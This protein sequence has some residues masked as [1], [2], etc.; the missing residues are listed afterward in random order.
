MF[1]WLTTL[2]FVLVLPVLA[3]AQ[4]DS[5]LITDAAPEVGIVRN[6]RGNHVWSPDSANFYLLTAFCFVENG[7]TLTIEP[8]TVIK[9]EPG[10]GADAS[11]LIV[12]RGGHIIADGTADRPIIFT[13]QSDDVDD[14]NDL[15]QNIRGLWGGLLVLGI[16]GT[17]VAG[18][19]N[20]IEGIPTTEPRGIYGPGSSFVKDD[21]DN[22]GIVRYVS[23]RYGGSV[24]GLNNE[25]NG[26]TLGAVGDGTT[27]EYV[28]SFNN[29]DDGFE[30]FGG[31]VNTRYLVS[32]R[33]DDD[34]F[35]YD[36]GWRG[37]NQFWL[38]LMDS[39]D[40]N[41]GGEHDGGTTPEDGTPYATPTIS[42][43]TYV[44]AGAT[45]LNAGNDWAVNLRDNAGG[46]YYNSIFTDFFGSGVQIEDLVSGQDSRQ[47]LDD[48]HLKFE[49]NIFW[50]FG[51]GNASTD[52]WPQPFVETYMT[53]GANDNDIVD[54]Q[55]TGMPSAS[56]DPLADFDPRPA[57]GSPAA[58]GAV[59]P[60]DLFFTSVS[61]K[62]AFEPGG[63]NWALGWTALDFQG[64]FAVGCLIAVAGDV[65]A[66][67]TITSA[68]I[69][70]LVNFVFKGGVAPSP[71]EAN[72]DVNCSGSVTSADIITMV[73]FVF[74]GG[75]APCD[76]CSDSPMSCP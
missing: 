19:S 18:D 32:A 9:G 46:F 22:S 8:G 54:P 56:R 20:S 24:I 75:A 30:W 13:A 1:R 34:G 11:A 2:C 39:A 73:N 53:E 47:R 45:G 29:A 55:I 25:I 40:G 66:S 76:I 16:A 26:L 4:L 64:Y 28:E 71:C 58:S 67:G 50:A 14:P 38:I 17:N 65:N 15:P 21:N 35:D 31:T 27:I 62:G 68:D 33:N 69:I 6:M 37:K 59:I 36:E 74:K 48:G 52:L 72:G 57:L 44:G 3:A 63:V 43:A 49:H 5:I 70:T 10:Q 12:A 42:N 7:D 23:I 60:V 41:S 61:Y 51:N